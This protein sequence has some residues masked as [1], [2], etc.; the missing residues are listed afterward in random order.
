[1][2]R[3]DLYRGITIYG[4]IA[5][6]RK[7]GVRTRT[8]V[9]DESKWVKREVPELRV[10]TDELWEAAHAQTVATSARYLRRGNQLIAQAESTKGKFLLSGF[11]AC[12]ADAVSSRANGGT[13]C[14]AP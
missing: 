14:G 13:V 9:T 6:G 12:G 2:L 3:R 1:V 5:R 7:K 11:L 10:V 8:R 4:R